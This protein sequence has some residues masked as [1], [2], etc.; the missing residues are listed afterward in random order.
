[1]KIIKILVLVFTF[2][3]IFLFTAESSNAFPRHRFARVHRIA[4]RYRVVPIGSY[5]YVRP[6]VVVVKPRHHHR[7]VR[8]IVY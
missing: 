4:P 1:M 2:S 6:Q 3:C 7:R 5:Y 8:L